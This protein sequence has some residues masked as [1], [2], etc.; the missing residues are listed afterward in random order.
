MEL[1]HAAAAYTP[2]GT[3]AE[4]Q[5]LSSATVT[6]PH[7]KPSQVASWR[8]PWHSPAHAGAVRKSSGHS[9][10]VRQHLSPSQHRPEPGSQWPDAH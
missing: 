4:A 8:V 7:T 9:E 3:R 1:E 2:H 10:A 5:P 6:V